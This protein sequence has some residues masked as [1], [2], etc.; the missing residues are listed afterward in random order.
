MAIGDAVG[1]GAGA[2]E[3]RRGARLASLTPM[4]GHLWFLAVSGSEVVLMTTKLDG[5]AT[6][7]PVE[8]V[9]RMPRRDVMSAVP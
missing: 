8:V 4:F 1:G 6:V 3:R 5:M 2:E 7:I 9:A